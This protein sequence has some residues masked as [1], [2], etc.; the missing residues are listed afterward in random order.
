M[1]SDYQRIEHILTAIQKIYDVIPE[2]EEE[3]L[4]S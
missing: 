2:T 1:I 3:F 4:M